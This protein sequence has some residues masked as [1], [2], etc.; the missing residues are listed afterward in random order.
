MRTGLQHCVVVLADRCHRAAK[1]NGYEH[2]IG[3]I[4][5]GSYLES[6]VSRFKRFAEDDLVKV[7]H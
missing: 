2:R 7:R 5:Y 6:L 4:I 1:K 3:E